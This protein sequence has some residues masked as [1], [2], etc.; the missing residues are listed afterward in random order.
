MKKTLDL[1]FADQVTFKLP[2]QVKEGTSTAPALQVTEGA[3]TSATGTAKG[4]EPMETEQEMVIEQP[5]T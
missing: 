2:Y 1:D 5:V 3:S 4:K